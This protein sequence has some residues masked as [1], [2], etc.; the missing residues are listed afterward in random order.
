M[1]RPALQ[2]GSLLLIYVVIA[3]FVAAA[4]GAIVWKYNSAVENAVKLEGER[5]E[6]LRANQEQLADNMWLRVENTRVNGLLTAREAGR[7][8][9]A[10]ERG[11]IRN[12]LE[13]VYRLNR[14]AR[15][16]GDQPVPGSVIDSMR[17]KPA[18]ALVDKNPKGASAV[19]PGR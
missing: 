19:K 3:I 17:L 2:R 18:E 12:A 13:N 1:N 8:A 5:D 16:W 4:G 15:L 6:A 11:E 14:E 7:Q 9:A 10:R